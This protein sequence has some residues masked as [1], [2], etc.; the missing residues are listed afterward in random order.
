MSR[1]LP[2]LCEDS[3]DAVVARP[4]IHGEWRENALTLNK[5][6]RHRCFHD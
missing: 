5:N 6:R 4:G 3:H 2:T 1:G